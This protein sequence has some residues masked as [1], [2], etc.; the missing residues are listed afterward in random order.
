MSRTRRT[1]IVATLLTLLCA[2]ALYG[3]YLRHLGE[4]QRESE[5]LESFRREFRPLLDRARSIMDDTADP[6]S[7]EE[8]DGALAGRNRFYPEF[9]PEVTRPEVE[10]LELTDADVNGDEAALSVSYVIGYYGPDGSRVDWFESR[11]V[12]TWHARRRD[13]RWVVYQV[14]A[15]LG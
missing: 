10:W 9:Y 2:G 3:L 4:V 8:L 7:S 14:D 12:E 11:D 5:R 13:G 1:A 15:P 6:P